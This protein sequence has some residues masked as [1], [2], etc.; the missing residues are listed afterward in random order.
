[1]RLGEAITATGDFKN[2]VRDWQNQSKDNKEIEYEEPVGALVATE[3]IATMP[4]LLYLYLQK[5]EKRSRG[6]KNKTKS[7]FYFIF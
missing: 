5:K 1:M 7:L 6:L 3:T 2:E 4:C